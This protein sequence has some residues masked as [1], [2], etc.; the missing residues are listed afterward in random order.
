MYVLPLVQRELIVALRRRSTFRLRMI[1]GAGTMG[2]VIWAFLVWGTS[3][4][5]AGVTLFYVFCWI[6]EVSAVFASILVAS[7]SISLERREG[8]L[9]FLFLAEL[10]ASDIVLGKLAAAGVVPLFTLLAIFPALAVCQLMGGLRNADLWQA[11][12]AL[13]ITLFVSLSAT[14]L[15]SSVGR[16]RRTVVLGAVFL[17]VLFDPL[18]LLYFASG[19]GALRFWAALLG[20]LALGTLF[21]FLTAVIVNRTW[22]EQPKERKAAKQLQA[23]SSDRSRTVLDELP[24][25]WMM[26]RRRQLGLAMRY[27]LAVTLI[28][29]GILI[30][31]W[32]AVPARR[33]AGLIA[34]FLLH[35]GCLLSLLAGTAYSFYNDRQ[36]G[37]LELLLGTPLS[38][39]QIIE[40]FAHFL[41]KQ[42]AIFLG[43]LSI[44]DCLLS[45]VLW[46]KNEHELA[47]FPIAMAATVWIS[48]YG[49]QWVGIYRSLM[50]NHPSISMIATFSRLCFFPL[51][52][53]ALFLWAP[54]TNY[55][56]VA[57]YWIVSSGFLA[58]LFGNDA[59]RVLIERGR[60]LLLRPYSEKPP[61]IESDWSF[62]NWD[63]VLQENTPE[64]PALREISSRS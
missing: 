44:V 58:L 40:G 48:F 39:E 57:V 5:S 64:F 8:T 47:V 38:N 27:G 42:S 23:I 37:T 24:V 49:V 62:I 35:M 18:W 36:E 29:A 60:T 2:A 46:T 53:S 61:H 20:Y 30:G 28:L 59:R 33:I 52:T 25:T 9:P 41:R 13:L 26:L 55:L 51:V 31:S 14:L 1:A 45:V 56:K 22:R 6:A 19:P 4:N 21:V 16:Q 3:A 15:A 32:L 12:F 43:L 11:F 17:L 54:R 7:D 34:L 63:E 10:N 50:M